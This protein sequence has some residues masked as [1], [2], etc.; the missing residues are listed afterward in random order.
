MRSHQTSNLN[1]NKKGQQCRP[2]VFVWF[3]NIEFGSLC[4]L[5]FQGFYLA[6]GASDLDDVD[7]SF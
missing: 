3:I 4:L 1:H 7:T 5:E 6:A 2:F